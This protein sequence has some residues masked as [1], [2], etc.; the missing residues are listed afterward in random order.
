MGLVL[1]GGRSDIRCGRPTLQQG[2][3]PCNATVAIFAGIVTV[4]TEI[5]ISPLVG[6]RIVTT[7]GGTAGAA[8]LGGSIIVVAITDRRIVEVD[9]GVVMDRAAAVMGMT[10]DTAGNVT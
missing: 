2:E 6:I 4:E 10:I 7:V 8:E 9:G 3:E 1:G 5:G